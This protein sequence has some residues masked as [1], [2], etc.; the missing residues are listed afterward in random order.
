MKQAELGIVV[1]RLFLFT[2]FNIRNSVSGKLLHQ[3]LL[4][5]LL[6]CGRKWNVAYMFAEPSMEPT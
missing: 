3:S 6:Q 2:T 1:G 4:M 5:L